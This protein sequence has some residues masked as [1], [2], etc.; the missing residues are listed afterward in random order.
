MIAA[1]AHLRPVVGQE[2]ERK[3][4]GHVLLE[5][6]RAVLAG[7]IAAEGAVGN[8]RPLCPVQRHTM[9]SDIWLTWDT[10]ASALVPIEE[11]CA[12]QERP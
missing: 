4:A 10:V 5:Y 8:V 2:A 7:R 11:R 3:R 1:L 6:S 12:Y 9:A